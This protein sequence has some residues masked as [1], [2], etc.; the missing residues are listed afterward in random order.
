MLY[1]LQ[2]FIKKK[3]KKHFPAASALDE[4]DD[5]IQVKPSLPPLGLACFVVRTET[6]Q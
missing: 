4:R 5:I 2:Q 3:K 1:P 6:L